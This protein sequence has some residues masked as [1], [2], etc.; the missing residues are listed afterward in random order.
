MACGKPCGLTKPR[1]K[2]GEFFYNVASNF[3]KSLKDVSPFS[4]KMEGSL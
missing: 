3:L 2:I 1:L 4:G